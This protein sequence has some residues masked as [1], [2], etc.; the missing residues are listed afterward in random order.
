MHLCISHRLRLH[1]PS[2]SRYASVVPKKIAHLH[3]PTYAISV[4]EIVLGFLI[5]LLK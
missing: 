3:I 4:I 5:F 1:A 2:T